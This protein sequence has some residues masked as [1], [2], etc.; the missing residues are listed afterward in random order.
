M[1]AAIDP[2]VYELV[3]PGIYFGEMVAMNRFHFVSKKIP[4]GY[5]CGLG[6]KGG[7]VDTRLLHIDADIVAADVLP[8]ID[9][10][11]FR[12]GTVDEL[13]L[14]G[15]RFPALQLERPIV[16]FGTVIDIPDDLYGNLHVSYL[17]GDHVGR[18]F[19]VRHLEQIWPARYRFL[20]VEKG[21]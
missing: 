2:K 4:K 15:L 1:N 13:L 21:K 12:A 8:L 5:S 9:S 19:D 20:V 10:L 18:D 6:H 17:G 14:F 3:H 7:F 11:G 16:A